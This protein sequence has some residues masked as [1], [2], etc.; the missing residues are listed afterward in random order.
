MNDIFTLNVKNE[1][2]LS[3]LSVSPASSRGNGTYY[4]EHMFTKVGSY[5]LELLLTDGQ[6]NYISGSPFEGVKVVVADVQAEHSQLHNFEETIIAGDTHTYQIQAY[7]I[8]ENIVEGGSELFEFEI[9]NK[10]TGQLTLAEIDYHFKLYHAT[11]RLTEAGD[12]SAVVKHTQKGGLRATYYE[13]T[14]F[15]APYRH[16]CLHN[17]DG[18]GS[19]EG[20]Q[21]SDLLKELNETAFYTQIDHLISFDNQERAFTLENGQHFPSQYFSIKWEGFLE[22]E[23]SERYRFYVEAYKTAQFEL[24]LNGEPVVQNS[25]DSETLLPNSAYFPSQ[26]LDMRAGLVK[27]ELRYAEQLGSSKLRLFWESNSQPFA[28]IPAQNFYYTLHS[29]H[30]PFNF[31]VRPAS[32][33]QTTSYIAELDLIAKAVVDV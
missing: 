14:D 24:L 22:I 28:E 20:P 31:H 4:L 32:T 21:T 27:I 10:Q 9:R 16:Q 8:F 29:R 3:V 23:H 18:H 11:F 17:H 33:N 5:T 26:D 2:D 30:T 25:F 13:T 1:T 12:Y 6:D 15:Q 19:H 7:D